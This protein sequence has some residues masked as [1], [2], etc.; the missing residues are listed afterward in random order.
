MA[1]ELV[2][3]N[4]LGRYPLRVPVRELAEVL[5]PLF[6]GKRVPIEHMGYLHFLRNPATMNDMLLEILCVEALCELMTKRVEYVVELY[7]GLGF[8][9]QVL[10]KFLK[11]KKHVIMEIDPACAK[12]LRL[13]NR[14]VEEG[15]AYELVGDHLGAD[16]YYMDHNTCSLINVPKALLAQLPK[17]KNARYWFWVDTAIAKLHMNLAAYERASGLKV[18]DFRSYLRALQ[19]RFFDQH[20]RTITHVRYFRNA[21]C[22]LVEKGEHQ[23]LQSLERIYLEE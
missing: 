22:L 19:K 18:T 20:E 14:K 11:P 2:E 12:I 15:D 13:N 1:E 7:G 3:F 17:L 5:R 16:L 21:A 9:S 4:L 8:A 10:D 6:E 23:P